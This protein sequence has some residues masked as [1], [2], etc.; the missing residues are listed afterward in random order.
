M[1]SQTVNHRLRI[2]LMAVSIFMFAGTV[3]ELL[4]VEHMESVVQL[5]PYFLSALGVISAI[6]FLVR[7]QRRTIWSLRGVM[8]VVVLGSLFGIYEHV[9]HNLE[10]ALEIRPNAVA[11]DVWLQALDGANPLLAPGMLAVAALLAMAATYYHPALL[12]QSVSA[13]ERTS[14]VEVQ[15]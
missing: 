1:S 3:I 7:P 9:E 12:D 5:I 15:G 2:F 4:L 11:S 8:I 13:Q 14:A 6:V 10:F